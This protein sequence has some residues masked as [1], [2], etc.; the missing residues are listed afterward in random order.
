MQLHD[1]EEIVWQTNSSDMVL[2]NFRFR[3]TVKGVTRK[4][5]SVMLQQILS[6]S[7]MR[8]HKPILLVLSALSLL[9]L[10][11]RN[12]P[13][14]LEPACFIL[15]F[16]FLL[17]YAATIKVSIVIHTSAQPIE[18]PIGFHSSAFAEELIDAIELA[19]IELRPVLQFAGEA[20]P[21]GSCRGLRELTQPRPQFPFTGA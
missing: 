6:C 7:Y 1:D 13:R 5:Q 20:T 16:F 11:V 17:W 19:L 2:T 15:I 3:Y 14:L 4:V 10:F 9:G 18:I 8:T 21:D 12:T